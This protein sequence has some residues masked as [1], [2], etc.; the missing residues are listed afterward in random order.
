MFLHFE[1]DLIGSA[2]R[3]VGGTPGSL[4]EVVLPEEVLRLPDELARVDTLLDDPAF[5]AAFTP[6]FDP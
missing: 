4:R 6:F 2:I 1:R 5:F 3:N